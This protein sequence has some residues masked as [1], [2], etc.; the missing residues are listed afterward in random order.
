VA[1]EDLTSLPEAERPPGGARD[2]LRTRNVAAPCDV[3]GVRPEVM[4]IP[5]RGRGVRCAA[6]CG[7]CP[8]AAQEPEG[9]AW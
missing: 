4:H 3:C 9:G 7:N 2:C 1:N 6:H 5:M 8:A